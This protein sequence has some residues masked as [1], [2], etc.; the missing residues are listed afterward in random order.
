MSNRIEVSPELIDSY[1]GNLDKLLYAWVYGI[2]SSTFPYRVS[3]SKGSLAT[4]I[5]DSA[6]SVDSLYAAMAKVF[7]STKSYCQKASIKF[8]KSDE[9]N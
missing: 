1:Q 7:H 4:K 5:H 9:I 8:S 2:E 6:P 3:V